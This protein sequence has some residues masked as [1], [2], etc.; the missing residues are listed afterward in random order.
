VTKKG[1]LGTGGLPALLRAGFLRA[2]S[3]SGDGGREEA[4][5][6]WRGN[7]RSWGS[8]SQCR[9]FPITSVSH[10]EAASSACVGGF[11][12]TQSM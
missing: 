12:Y 1:P 2:R 5:V 9:G 11:V 4:G 8:L 3:A 7:A 10:G 6:P